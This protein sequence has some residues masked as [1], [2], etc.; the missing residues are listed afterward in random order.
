MFSFVQKTMLYM[1]QKGNII[2]LRF[3]KRVFTF[4][5]S[6]VVTSEDKEKLAATAW[7]VLIETDRRA[8]V[9]GGLLDHI[10]SDTKEVVSN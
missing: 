9:V 1:R 3:I 4:D 7:D 6:F 10:F 5:F 2:M 8:D